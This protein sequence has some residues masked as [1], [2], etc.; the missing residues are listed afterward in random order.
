MSEKKVNFQ[1]LYS[2]R[3]SRLR[4]PYIS[5]AEII[6]FVIIIKIT[7]INEFCEENDF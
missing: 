4:W 2:T 1:D 6:G 7:I 5:S 3:Y